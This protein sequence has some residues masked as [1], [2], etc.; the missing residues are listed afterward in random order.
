M[1]RDVI[2]GKTNK[3]LESRALIFDPSAEIPNSLKRLLALGGYEVMT[4]VNM[5]D[6]CETLRTFS[7][8]VAF[9]GAS[10]G[11]NGLAGFL[12]RARSGILCFLVT[13]ENSIG[14]ELDAAYMGAD[15]HVRLPITLAK[16]DSLLDGHF[17]FKARR[18]IGG[19]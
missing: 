17:A 5:A 16:L 18:T 6:V 14:A 11:K 15:G 4:P 8:D 2:S 3:V 7:V 1:D 13:P 19:R 9:F 12:K 10:S